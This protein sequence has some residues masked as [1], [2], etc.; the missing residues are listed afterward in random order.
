M[1][2]IKGYPSQEKEDRTKAQFV[3]VS[4]IGLTRFGLDVMA[5]S[6]VSEVGTDAAEAGTT[7]IQIAA[8][9]H[10]AQPGDIIR[11]TSGS[12]AGVEVG[13]LATDTDTIDLAE[14]LSAALSPGDSFQILRFTRPLV[15]SGGG[16]SSALSFTRD[17][18]TQIVTEDTVTPA[19]NRPLPV[20]LTSFD[21]DMVLNAA[22]L[23]LEVQLDHSSAN[24]D[25]VQIGDGT[26]TLAINADGSINADTGLQTDD[27]A[28][29]ATTLRNTPATDAVHLLSTRHEDVNTPLATRLSNGSVAIDNAAIAASQKTIATAA[30]TLVT[31]DFVLGWD[32][33]THRELAVDTSGQVKTFP[34][35]TATH[36]LDTRHEAANTPLSIQLS[37]G[38]VFMDT[39]AI[40]A[41]QKTIATATSTQVNTVFNLGW[42]GSTHR[43][44]A[45]DTA[46]Q[47]KTFPDATATHL[48]DTR[49][50][51]VG[52]PLSVR[53]GDGTNFIDSAPIG[54]AQQAVSSFTKAVVIEGPVL[55]WDG[56]DHREIAV[57]TDGRLK[58]SNNDTVSK[59]WI[60][61][62][63]Y[64]SSSVAT[65]SY[66]Q[67]EAST[68]SAIS[69]LQ[70]FDSSGQTLVLATGAAASEVDQFY[71]PPGGIDID[72][73][74]PSGTRISI[75]AISATADAG[76]ITITAT[77]RS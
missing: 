23:N 62:R 63:D 39:A 61:R 68:T 70:I 16:L 22:N 58:T 41:S 72:I 7:A 38:S 4:Q 6:F 13:V 27:G 2:G 77:S 56:A 57:E 19:N 46:G 15:S 25:S 71:I 43:E 14:T 31:T 3:T 74:I 55:G 21:G 11:V 67:L 8:T 45:V 60:H 37:D 5:H 64:S 40:A 51:A 12:L 33:S 76:E 48:L 24:P 53:L 52:T 28:I 42:D 9:A 44:L 73:D 29:T 75:K 49:H 50:E 18:S 47:V 20:K 54:G 69:K 17:G 65:G 26:E 1:S 30:A 36:L 10:A 66:T 35:A 32:G 34:D 59:A